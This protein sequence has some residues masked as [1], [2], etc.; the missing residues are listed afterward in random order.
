MLQDLFHSKEG[1]HTK[2][3]SF[4]RLLSYRYLVGLLNKKIDVTR[5]RIRALLARLLNRPF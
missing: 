3:R 5:F 1:N 2:K 4:R